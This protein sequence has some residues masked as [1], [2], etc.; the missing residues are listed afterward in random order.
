M[1]LTAS[2]RTSGGSLRTEILVDGRHHLTTDE[3]ARLGGTDTGPAPHELVPAALAAC[4]TT[5]VQ[6][7]AR[8]KGWEL[9]EIAVDVVYDNTSTP[10]HFDVTVHLPDDLSD[11]QRRRLMRVAEACPVRRA[12]EAGMTFDEHLPDEVAA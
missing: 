10:R 4:V 2:A 6:A 3:P 11:E 9:D 5:T 12:I 1:S 7:Y 8:T